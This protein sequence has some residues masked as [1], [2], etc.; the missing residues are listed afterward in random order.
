MNMLER[1]VVFGSEGRMC[2]DYNP[3]QEYK[4]TV[5]DCHCGYGSLAE[6]IC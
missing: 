5:A 1:V 3:N 6:K 2:E 4:N